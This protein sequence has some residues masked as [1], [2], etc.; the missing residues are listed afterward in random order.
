MGRVGSIA[1]TSELTVKFTDQ[2]IHAGGGIVASPVSQT[3]SNP[4]QPR[5]DRAGIQVTPDEGFACLV[6]WSP[7]RWA[8]GAQQ[9]GCWAQPVSAAQ[10]HE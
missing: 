8:S 1:R 9:Q 10:Q 5:A 3:V 2:E 7:A 6:G 4:P